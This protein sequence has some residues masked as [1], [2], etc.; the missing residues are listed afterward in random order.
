M[1]ILDN[2]EK[3]MLRVGVRVSQ[4]SGRMLAKSVMAAGTAKK[5]AAAS[6]GRRQN[7]HQTTHEK[8]R[9]AAATGC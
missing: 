6:R 1:D 8:R 4:L 9:Q 7:Q 3:N 5:E 2:Y